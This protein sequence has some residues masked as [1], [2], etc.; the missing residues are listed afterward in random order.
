MGKLDSVDRISCS[1]EWLILLSLPQKLRLLIRSITDKTGNFRVKEGCGETTCARPMQ[2]VQACP[3]S[4]GSTTSLNSEIRPP[5]LYSVG[6]YSSVLVLACRVGSRVAF[7][8]T[9]VQAKEARQVSGHFLLL[10][11]PQPEFSMLESLA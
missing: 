1:L 9:Q 6:S 11:R 2:Q 7:C 8:K 10:L 4:L 5:G 3:S